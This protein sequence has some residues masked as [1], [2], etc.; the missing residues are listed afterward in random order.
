MEPTT[1]AAAMAGWKPAR[2]RSGITV[3]PTE[4]TRPEV[5]G[6]A[7][8]MKETTSMQAGR[9]RSPSLRSGFVRS[10]T[11]CTS[12]FVSAT[13]E[14]KPIAEQIAMMSEPFVIDL[15]NCLK[16]IIGSSERTAIRRPAV[17]RTRRVS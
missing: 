17:R 5:E 6:I 10:A 3:G 14:A 15:S 2:M 11:R 12:H 1:A 7:I 16:A 13:T 4:A 8:E 9:R